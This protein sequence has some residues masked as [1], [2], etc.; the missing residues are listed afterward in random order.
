MTTMPTPFRPRASDLWP[1]ECT[2]PVTRDCE[3]ARRRCKLEEH[4][5]EWES[6][7]AGERMTFD[8]GQREWAARWQAA[9]PR[10]AAIRVA[11][12]RIV[13]VASFIHS[14]SDAFEAARATAPVST[15]S[16]LVEQ[17]RLFARRPA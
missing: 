16:G 2:H 11:E 13:N 10:L 5:R 6:A 7:Y 3:H 9:A 8:E 15:T 12:L 1:G 17:Q 14:M 4:T